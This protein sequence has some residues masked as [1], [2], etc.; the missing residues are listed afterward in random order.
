[1]DGTARWRRLLEPLVSIG[2]YDMT[3]YLLISKRDVP[4]STA[5]EPAGTRRSDR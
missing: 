1:M 3:T 4:S 2:A 5:T